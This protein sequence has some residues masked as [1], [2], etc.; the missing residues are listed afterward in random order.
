RTPEVVA[1]NLIYPEKTKA[2]K[3][4]DKKTVVIVLRPPKAQN[5][6]RMASL[7]RSKKEVVEEIMEDA[8]RRNP[9]D[10]RPWVVVMDGA[11]GLWNLVA[12]MFC[13]TYYVGILDII[14]VVEYLWAAGNA[15]YG[16]NNPETDKQ[17][18]KKQLS[19]LQGNV[20][21]VIG[22]L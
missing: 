21:R 11:L 12:K 3:K 20:G 13:G 10:L 15:L 6:R 8:E 7:E 18:Y 4:A 17:V 19:I 22:G 5:I 1:D 14:H 2:D 16:E 9:D